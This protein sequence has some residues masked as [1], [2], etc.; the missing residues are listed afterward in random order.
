MWPSLAMLC[1][2]TP[3]RDIMPEK[4][5]KIPS[6]G[7][8]KNDFS[9][10]QDRE[11]VGGSGE[12]RDRE[13]A[14]GSGEGRDR[15]AVGGSGYNGDCEAASPCMPRRACLPDFLGRTLTLPHGPESWQRRGDGPD[16]LVLGLGPGSPWLT[17]LVQKAGRICWLE[18]EP[19]LQALPPLASRGGAGMSATSRQGRRC[20]RRRPG[21]SWRRD[22]RPP[23]G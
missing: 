12:G 13:A 5:Q 6:V 23:K 18:H 20:P 4:I 3:E 8:G 9:A 17:G 21:G 22:A 10:A 2:S 16:A 11:A 14:G 15:E 1:K 7:S 19:T